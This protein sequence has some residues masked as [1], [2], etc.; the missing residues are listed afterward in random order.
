MLRNRNK[1][2]VVLCVVIGAALILTACTIEV[3]TKVNEDGSGEFSYSFFISNEEVAL[4]MGEFGDYGLDINADE[5]CEGMG[6][7]FGDADFLNPPIVEAKETEDGIECLTTVPFNSI[8][9]LRLMHS[10][11]D[12]DEFFVELDSEGDFTYRVVASSEDLDAGDVQNYS[13]YGIDI[14]VLW[15]V[16]AP[17]EITSF[18]GSK[19]GNTVTWDLME[20]SQQGGT[21]TMEVRSEKGG[22]GIAIPEG[23]EDAFQPVVDFVEEFL[24]LVS[25]LVLCCCCGVMLLIG[26]I[27]YFLFFR[28]KDQI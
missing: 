21:V 18:N 19:N 3:H 4:F 14:S 15:K 8:D 24:G 2:L 11:S 5:I 1:S 28:K 25:L 23:L 26:G 7:E 27:V 13:D 22:G 20:L 17:G 16:T 9:Q 12:F 10:N 6:S